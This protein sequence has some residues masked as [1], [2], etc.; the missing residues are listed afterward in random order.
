MIWF[1]SDL[2]LGHENIIGYC[3]RPYA[4][5]DHMNIGL[6]DNWNMCVAEDDV[7]WVLGDLA[8]G[9]DRRE[10]LAWFGAEFQGEKHLVPGNHDKCWRGH[11][12][13]KSHQEWDAVYE[14]AGFEIH[15]GPV[16]LAIPMNEHVLKLVELCH[17]P[18]APVKDEYRDDRFD[19]FITWRPENHG[20]PLLHGHIHGK[21]NLHENMIDV[22]VDANNYMPIS[23]E[24][25][26][27]LVEKM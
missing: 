24:E 19:Q 26:V 1:T 8:M 9:R 6:R 16:E 7:V 5:V 12:S 10:T 22:G 3:D 17:F 4:S 20:Q 15:H 21:K 18:Y 14:A 2:H 23:L 11:G 13:V 27:R 25:I